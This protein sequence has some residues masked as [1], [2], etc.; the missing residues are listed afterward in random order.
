MAALHVLVAT[1]AAIVTAA[2]PPGPATDRGRSFAEIAGDPAAIPVSLGRGA[3]FTPPAHGSAV[4]RG[5]PVAGLR[6]SRAR[7]A[8]VGAHLELF[9]DRRVV[10][11]PA[12]IGIAPPHSGVGAYVH[13]GA[14]S[15]AARTREPTGLIELDPNSRRVTL[16]DL[17]EIW[18]QPLSRRRLAGFTAASGGVRAYIAGRRWRSD[19]RAIPLQRHS[20]I[21]LQLGRALPPHR[22]YIFPEAL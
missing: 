4:R 21:V 12:G 8:R 7:A 15:Y 14:C 11:I 13:R 10:R 20:V 18:G 3:R 19:P 22:R 17:F 6:C 5:R 16:G 2:P 1:L 9:V